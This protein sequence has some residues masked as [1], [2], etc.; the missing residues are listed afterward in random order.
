M[1]EWY[2][3]RLKE[4]GIQSKPIFKKK[5]LFERERKES[6]VNDQE[7]ELVSSP[8]FVLWFSPDCGLFPR[9]KITH[10]QALAHSEC[11]AAYS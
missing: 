11:K 7:A 4:H 10:S 9:L 8:F 5:S 1:T 6:D 3:Y 2:K